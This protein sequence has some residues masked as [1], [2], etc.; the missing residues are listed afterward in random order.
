MLKSQTQA[1]Y[2][3]SLESE[4]ASQKARLD[5]AE[6]LKE[7]FLALLSTCEEFE[8]RV[9]GL[10]TRAAEFAGRQDFARA[11][12]E[13]LEKEISVNNTELSELEIK[14][15]KCEENTRIARNLRANLSQNLD[16]LS[17]NLSQNIEKG[18]K[19][20]SD[21]KELMRAVHAR[22]TK[23]EKD[24]DS[25]EHR[26]D[27]LETK[28]TS[29][30]EEIESTHKAVINAT[31]KIPDD[32]DE[33]ERGDEQNVVSPDVVTNGVEEKTDGLSAPAVSSFRGPPHVHPASAA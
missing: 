26:M 22:T 17:Q 33:Y 1:V 14:T 19:L 24:R 29:K 8:T 31:V 9:S 7:M 6:R 23:L 2:I 21:T 5:G 16:N 3:P 12:Q 32:S 25:M 10:E 15:N 4:V 28:P 27:L 11:V 13:R 18:S 30:K 20:A